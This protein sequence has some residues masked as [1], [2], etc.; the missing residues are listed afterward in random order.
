MLDLTNRY[1]FLA[2]AILFEGSLI[3]IAEVLG[4]W[5][6]IRPFASLVCDW[7]GVIW[8]LAAT[9]PM[10]ALFLLGNRYPIGPLREIK[11]FL[12][13]A[14]GPSLAAC[15]W[16][17]LLLIGAVAGFGEEI[18]FRGVLQPLIGQLWSN[19]V[20]G[21]VHFVTPTYALLAGLLGGYLGWLLKASENLLAP[22]IAHGLYDF[23]AFLVVARECR[24]PV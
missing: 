5:F 3:G 22:I 15:R 20:F 17:D 14:L 21:L 8:G 7:R 13:D 1:N 6:D 16:Y 18:L 24:K 12:V 19:V 4:W 11:Q 9:V 23:L 10:F 2:V